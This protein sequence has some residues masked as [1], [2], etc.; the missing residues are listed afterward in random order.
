MNN[1]D[2]QEYKFENTVEKLFKT[3]KVKKELAETDPK[4]FEDADL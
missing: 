4:R 2:Y 3:K 1:N